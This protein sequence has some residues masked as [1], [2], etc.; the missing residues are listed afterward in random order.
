MP[1]STYRVTTDQ[2]VFDVTVDEGGTTSPQSDSGAIGTAAVG[3]GIPAAARGLMAFGTS[4]TAAKTG[5]VIG[6]VVGAVAPMIQGAFHGPM[7]GVTGALEAPIT[8][9]AGGKT[10]YFGTKMLQD[11][12]RPTSGALEKLAPLGRILTRASGA[13]GLGDLAQMAEPNRRDIGF[14]GMGASQPEPEPAPAMTPEQRAA[15][16]KTWQAKIGRLYGRLKR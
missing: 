6:R 15:Y 4:P 1:Q 12:A 3:S 10:G 7:A 2:G 8:S 14:L 16:E 9:W 5:G 13:Q 11:V